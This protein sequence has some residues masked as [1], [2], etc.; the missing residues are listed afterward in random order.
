MKKL[1]L[2][3]SVL[4]LVA[5]KKDPI[6]I[7]KLNYNFFENG[8]PKKPTIQIQETYRTWNN[9]ITYYSI[10]GQLDFRTYPRLPKKFMLKLG[11]RN[12]EMVTRIKEVPPKDSIR[13]FILQ[14]SD[15]I[16]DT[17]RVRIELFFDD[18]TINAFDKIDQRYF[19]PIK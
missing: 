7:E 5:C 3:L 17:N 15:Y 8:Y 19:F 9:P 16:A 1:V 14:V 10:K 18:D 4:I 2:L 11:W 13:E 6:E 12:G